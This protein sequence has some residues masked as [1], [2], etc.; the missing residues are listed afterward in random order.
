M[1]LTCS[2]SGDRTAMAAYIDD[3]AAIG[4]R[5]GVTQWL[6]HWIGLMGEL[7]LPWSPSKIEGLAQRVR[8]LGIVCRLI[9]V[10]MIIILF[11]V[12]RSFFV[13]FL[14]IV[15]AVFNGFFI[16]EVFSWRCSPAQVFDV[17]AYLL[18]SFR[19]AS[20]R[21]SRFSAVEPE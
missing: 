12:A 18:R 17:G 16:L 15:V 1:T 13:F 6:A 8:F 19:L 11:P 5:S 4:T 2:F 3:Y 21:K 7:G 20:I 10:F 9:I 14:R